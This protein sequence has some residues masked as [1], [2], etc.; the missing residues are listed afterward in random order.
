[1]R[2]LLDT[3]ICIYLIKRRPESVLTR[4]NELSAGDIGISSIT[5]Y[6]MAYGAEKSNNTI[7]SLQALQHFLSPLTLLPFDDEDAH[8][9][10]NIRA[11]LAKIEQPIGPYD[12]QIAGQARRRNLILITNNMGEFSRV[13]D[14]KS[15]N[16]I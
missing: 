4:F 15:E 7:K 8:E 9:A 16:W 11:Y 5:V 3:N 6:E 13:P 1:M 12:V 14:L 10:G 2:Y